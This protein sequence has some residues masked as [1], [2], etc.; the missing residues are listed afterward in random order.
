L[1][2]IKSNIEIESEQYRLNM[3]DNQLILSE[4]KNRL[5][6]VFNRDEEPS[7]RK[8]ISGQISGSKAY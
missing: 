8:H 3:A 7:V 1:K 5:L 6:A 2:Q 4:Y